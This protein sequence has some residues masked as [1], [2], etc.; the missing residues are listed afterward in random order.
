MS[1]PNF[2][3]ILQGRDF[4]CWFGMEWPI[5]KIENFQKENRITENTHKTRRNRWV[6]YVNHKSLWFSC[7]NYSASLLNDCRVKIVVYMITPR[8]LF[9]FRVQPV[10][11]IKKNWVVIF[12]QT[13][14]DLN[15][16]KA[17]ITKGNDTIITIF[18]F[19]ARF[20][21]WPHSLRQIMP[22]KL[23]CALNYLIIMHKYNRYTP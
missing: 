13:C 17:L 4:F 16:Q 22:Y 5:I 3:K 11:K 8:N 2:M 18:S 6:D 20:S 1:V 21:E 14:W 10:H 23:H 15:H 7:P 12:V 9:L 19:T